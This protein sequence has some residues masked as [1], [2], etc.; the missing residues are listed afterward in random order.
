MTPFK[1]YLGFDAPSD[2]SPVM[3][4]RHCQICNVPT[5][6][7]WMDRALCDGCLDDMAEY[8][9]HVHGEEYATPAP[10]ALAYIAEA[11]EKLAEAYWESHDEMRYEHP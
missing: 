4:R 8:F 5:D 10:V 6:G 3:P 7:L 2:A 9:G 1:R 11:R